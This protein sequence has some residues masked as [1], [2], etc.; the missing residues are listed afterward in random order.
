[1]DVKMNRIKDAN[2]ENHLRGVEISL[3][4]GEIPKGSL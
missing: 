3:I 4:D 2:F 1:V